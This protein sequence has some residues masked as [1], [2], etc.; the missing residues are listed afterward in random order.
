MAKT[1]YRR[2]NDIICPKCNTNNQHEQ[3]RLQYVAESMQVVNN[4]EVVTP[5]FIAVYCFKCGFRLGDFIPF[6][7][8][9][10]ASAI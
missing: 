3:R 1:K 9:N 7:G 5:E 6:D 10:D 2:A 8:A 4:T